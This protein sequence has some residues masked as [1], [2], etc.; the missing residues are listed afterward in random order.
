MCTP[1]DAAVD[2]FEVPRTRDGIVA[3]IGVR[4]RLDGKISVAVGDYAAAGLH[5]VD[6]SVTMASWLRH[7]ARFD[8]EGAAR[9]AR[10]AGKLHRLPV[11][12]AASITGALSSG[13]VDAVLAQVPKRHV[14]LFAEHEASV[15]P[16][17]VGLDIDGIT[18]AMREWRARADAINPGPAPADKPDSVRLSTTLDDRGVLNGSLG[19]DLTNLLATALR[20][21][22]CGDLSLPRDERQAMALGQICQTFLD[23]N[24]DAKHRRHRPHLTVTVRE[25]GTATYLDTGMPV[26]RYGLDTLNCDAAWHRLDFAGRAAILRYGRTMR[27]WPVELYN[28]IAI[29]DGGCRWPGCTAPVHWCDVH[30]AIFWEHGG[31]TDIDHGL[32]LCRRHHRKLHSKDRWILKL[33]PDGTAELTHPDGTTETSYPKGLDPPRLPLPPV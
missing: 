27:D 22:D 30:H 32:L 19:A 13:A 3:A 9:G 29:R 5:E 12:S 16:T 4:D 2:A 18:R 7:Y 10:R 20:V 33:L 25:D 11:L 8:S 15:V 26:S 17:L 1:L 31:H 28:A 24:P 23:F 6:G 14:G 21:A